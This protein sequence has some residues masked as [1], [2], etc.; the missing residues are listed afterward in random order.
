MK[1]LNPFSDNC[2]QLKFGDYIL[3]QEY[4][5][6][7]YK[8]VFK[9]TKPIFAIYL[10]FF[11]ADQAFAFNYVKWVNENREEVYDIDNHI[12]WSDYINILGIWKVKPTWQEIISKYRNQEIDEYVDS[13]DI[14]WNDIKN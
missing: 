6:R 8:G 13:D 9:V 2:N 5:D 10:G 3:F 7:N 4:Q 12:E 14:D 11:V 1:K